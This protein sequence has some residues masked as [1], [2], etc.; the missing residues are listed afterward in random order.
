[1]AAA[2][3]NGI[4][5]GTGVTCP[6]LRYNPAIFSQ[7]AATVDRMSKGNFYLGVGTGE[8]TNEYPTTGLWL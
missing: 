5:T 3:L 1:M 6:I 8:E 2:R 4:E 7:S